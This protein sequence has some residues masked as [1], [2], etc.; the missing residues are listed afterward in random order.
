MEK[1]QKKEAASKVVNVIAVVLLLYVMLAS[2]TKRVFVGSEESIYW[3]LQFERCQ[4][5]RKDCESLLN[6]CVEAGD[7]LLFCP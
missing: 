4:V 7:L 2:C 1:V 3:R 6:E 5:D